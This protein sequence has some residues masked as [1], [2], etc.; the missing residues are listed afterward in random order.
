MFTM[1]LM[2]DIELAQHCSEHGLLP[3]DLVVVAAV[4]MWRMVAVGQPPGPALLVRICLSAV[5]ALAPELAV[6][7]HAG[8]P[9][10]ADIPFAKQSSDHGRSLHS[11][12]PPAA[13][14][15]DN[16]QPYEANDGP[17]AGP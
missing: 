11:A 5:T 13:V 2:V 4:R 1:P 14:Q 6:P 16:Q 8:D 12:H 10:V 3:Q 15:P 17:L 7:I 9:V